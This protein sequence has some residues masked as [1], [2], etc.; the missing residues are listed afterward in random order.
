MRDLVKYHIKPATKGLGVCYALFL[1]QD[2]P[3]KAKVMVSESILH[4]MILICHWMIFLRVEF[5]GIHSHY[6]LSFIAYS[7]FHHVFTA[8]MGRTIWLFCWLSREIR[9]RG[10]ILDLCFRHLPE[11]WC[12]WWSNHCWTT[13]KGSRVRALLNSIEEC[14]FD[15]GCCHLWMWYL[16]PKMVRV[17]ELNDCDFHCWMIFL[18]Y[19]FWFVVTVIST[20]QK[21]CLWV[22]CCTKIECE[23]QTGS[24]Q[25]RCVRTWANWKRWLYSC[26]H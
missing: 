9:W 7:T 1:N 25:Q 3:L 16:Y 2:K 6:P 5:L 8:Y 10:T 24:I 13:W 26:Y 15:A 14:R 18:T 11:Q 4:M 21:V 23:G 19:C 12:K 22:I 20:C 17:T